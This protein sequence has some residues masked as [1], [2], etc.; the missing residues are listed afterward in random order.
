MVFPGA[1]RCAAGAGPCKR[2]GPAAAQ[3]IFGFQQMVLQ[4]EAGLQTG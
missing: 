2:R 4:L 3:L 1:H